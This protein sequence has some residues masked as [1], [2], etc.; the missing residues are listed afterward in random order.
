MAFYKIV[1]DGYI[2]G[3]AKSDGEGN[4]TETEYNTV[5]EIIRNRP[6]APDG[7]QYRLTTGMEWE[8]YELL[9][10][11]P[12]ESETE[13]TETDYQNELRRLGVEA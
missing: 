7:Y 8:L 1:K 5:S 10:L 6:Q 3:V 4:V 13:A 12:E 11:P 2:L 9:E